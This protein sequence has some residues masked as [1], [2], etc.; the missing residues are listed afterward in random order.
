MS[1]L[2]SLV[3]YFRFRILA[4]GLVQ[5]GYLTIGLTYDVWFLIERQHYSCCFEATL[6]SSTGSLKSVWPWSS[7]YWAGPSFVSQHQP[8]FHIAIR[9]SLWNLGPQLLNY[10][11]K[12]CLFLHHPL[13]N[14]H[15]N[16]KTHHLI[17]F[18]ITI[19]GG[20]WDIVVGSHYNTKGLDYL[21]NRNSSLLS[22]F[23]R[24]TSNFQISD[25]I[26]FNF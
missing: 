23:R 2:L 13:I 3:V 6:S 9:G 16:H 19:L 26:T 22:L 12:E 7:Q 5:A 17:D 14:C 1:Y 10:L 4:L 8:V 15:P 18:Q 21:R 25:T 11:T 24:F 20:A